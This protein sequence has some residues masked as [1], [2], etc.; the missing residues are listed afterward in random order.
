MSEK[1][2][3]NCIFLQFY[4]KEIEEKFVND[5]N[6]NV[7]KYNI[8]MILFIFLFSIAAS[9]SISF[10]YLQYDTDSFKAI[11][12]TS[13]LITFI[14]IFIIIFGIIYRKSLNVQKIL[15][16]VN[17]IS[18]LF[19]YVNL[20]YPLVIYIQISSNV[21]YILICIDIIFRLIWKILGLVS[22]LEN[23]ILCLITVAFYWPLYASIAEASTISVTLTSMGA[24]TTAI[25]IAVIFSYFIDKQQKKAFYYFYTANQKAERFSNI[26][27]N[28]NSGF[29]SIKGNKISYIN[30]FLIK[31]IES[32]KVLKENLDNHIKTNTESKIYFIFSQLI[33]F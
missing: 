5:K 10:F 26:L 12:F 11:M 30:E 4:K 6:M 27:D 21:F 3:K 24:Y 9:T 25:T 28:I 16:Y 31:I 32:N 19:V 8:Y 1:I 33:Y 7:M 29:I 23:L 13:Y 2:F 17:Y 18:L 22:F 14:Y 20:R 15:N